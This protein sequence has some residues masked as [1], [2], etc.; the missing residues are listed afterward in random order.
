MRL[1]SS[2]SWHAESEV[3]YLARFEVVD[4]NRSEVVISVA[5]LQT[6]WCPNLVWA[7]HTV[8]FQACGQGIDKVDICLEYD[9][10]FSMKQKQ[11]KLS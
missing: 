2:H 8:Y 9:K 7:G 1:A 11:R 6:P 4:L 3:F 10:P 5:W